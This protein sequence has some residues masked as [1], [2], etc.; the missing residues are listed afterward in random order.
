M[1][2]KCHAD[3]ICHKSTDIK[4]SI[5]ATSVQTEWKKSDDENGKTRDDASVSRFCINFKRL[6]CNMIFAIF[7]KQLSSVE[8]SFIRRYSVT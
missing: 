6:H 2:I 3:V 4:I 1:V 7:G 8:T 5:E